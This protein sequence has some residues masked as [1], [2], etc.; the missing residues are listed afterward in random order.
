MRYF[1]ILLLG[2]YDGNREL[3]NLQVKYKQGFLLHVIL[4]PFLSSFSVNSLPLNVNKGIKIKFKRTLKNS[5]KLYLS[6]LC[7]LSEVSGNNRSNIYNG[8]NG[9]LEVG[10]LSTGHKTSFRGHETVN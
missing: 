5:L 6:L 8:S 2:G 4:N 3:Q 9:S 7:H 10:T 1:S